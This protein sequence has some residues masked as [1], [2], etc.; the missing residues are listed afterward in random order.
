M[1]GHRRVRV[2]EI[3]KYL[4]RK[5]VCKRCSLVVGVCG[6]GSGSNISPSLPPVQCPRVNDETN[7]K[8]LFRATDIIYLYC[9]QSR[10][11]D[12][13]TQDSRRLLLPLL[14]WPRLTL[15]ANHTGHT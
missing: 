6:D 5:W 2:Q 12:R 11:L 1:T 13:L 3:N 7:W 9:T 14:L 10:S 4:M 15:H 8:C